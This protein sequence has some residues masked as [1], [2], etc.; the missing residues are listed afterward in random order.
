M[1]CESL[2][3]DYFNATN[4]FLGENYL[5]L[6]TGAAGPATDV[7]RRFGFEEKCVCSC[8]AIA[9]QALSSPSDSHSVFF[10]LQ[11]HLADNSCAFD[12]IRAY[13]ALTYIAKSNG[14]K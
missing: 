4:N 9:M 3:N 8:F 7:D 14:I 1:G 13:I 2:P 6:L 11:V 5:L 10:L 12:Q